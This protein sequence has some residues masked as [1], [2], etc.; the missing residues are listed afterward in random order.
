[1]PLDQVLGRIH[2][3]LRPWSSVAACCAAIV[4]SACAGSETRDVQE[5]SGSVSTTPAAESEPELTATDVAAAKA[6]DQGE[7]QMPAPVVE[8]RAAVKPDAP[9]SYTVQR[10][11]TLW[12]LAN[13]FLRDPWL[14]PEIWQVN[15]QVE[16]PHLIFPGDVLALGYGA[17]GMPQI[18]LARGGAARLDPRLRTSPLDGAIA[19]IPYAAIAAFLERP[20]VLSREQ[21]RNAPTVLGFR[22]GHMVGASGNEAYVKGLKESAERSRYNVYRIGDRVV[23]PDD[24]ELLGYM[25][26]YAATAVVLRS[27]DT[28]KIVLEDTTRETLQGDPLIAADSD[29][30]LNFLPRAP[31]KNVNGEIIAVFDGTELIGQYRIVAINRGRS[32]GLEL[33]HVMAIDQRGE[34]VQDNTRRLFGKLAVKSSLVPRIK[35]PNERVGSLLVFKVY[36]RMSYGLTVSVTAPVRI[37]DKIRTP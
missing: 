28:S 9:A 3:N 16:N 36:D 25:G 37:G 2:L 24:G 10:G 30:P 23:D 6:G 12:D 17:N 31:A 21:I 1:M 8:A 14:W 15:P 35:L 33:G 34:E 27:A 13:L 22:D 29:V 18:S 7:A 4:L 32:Q 20:A 5:E 11:D 19:T 26:T